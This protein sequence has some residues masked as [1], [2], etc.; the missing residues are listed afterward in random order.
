MGLK[1][2]DI[3]QILDEA[4]FGDK[5]TLLKEEERTNKIVSKKARTITLPKITIS[6]DWGKVGTPDRQVLEFIVE[7]A[8]R[9]SAGR[10]P[11]RKLANMDNYLNFVVANLDK[12]FSISKLL[13]SIIIV[14]TM[15][16]MYNSFSISSSGFLNE[17]FMSVFYGKNA[18][19]ITASGAHGVEDIVVRKPNAYIS[20]KTLEKTRMDIEG[21]LKLL[22]K[23]LEQDAFG[24]K[25]LYHVFIKDS[26]K[27][28]IQ[29]IRMFEIPIHRS[30]IPVFYPD[31][32]DPKQAY[33]GL[34]YVVDRPPVPQAL[35]V[36][37]PQPA[38]T[39]EA[40]D[41]TEEEPEDTTT[42]SATTAHPTQSVSQ[43]PTTPAAKSKKKKKEPAPQYGPTVKPGPQPHEVDYSKALLRTVHL[44]KKDTVRETTEFRVPEK[45]W[46]RFISPGIP[47]EGFLL[48]L[49]DEKYTKVLERATQLLDEQI[50]V[51]FHSLDE[52]SKNITKFFTDGDTKSG[53]RAYLNAKELEEKTSKLISSDI[54][55]SSVKGIQ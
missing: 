15:R 32:V 13:S 44:H 10:D 39:N 2:E 14:E 55:G 18:E 1:I 37:Q 43:S 21:S 31:T 28:K 20:L 26:A 47:P 6:E 52:F 16:K 5:K 41:D 11:L 22:Q 36:K 38:L 53:L 45:T 9:G 49:S 33:M 8:S 34:V 40:E 30:S 3:F 42:Q 12:K 35:P 48:D 29:Q 19:Q 27:G 46:K 51:I 17:A 24:N 50:S 7:R 25:I 23:T 4:K 54:G